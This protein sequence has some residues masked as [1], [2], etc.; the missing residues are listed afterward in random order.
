MTAG[1]FFLVALA[2][3]ELLSAVVHGSMQATIIVFA[4]GGFALGSVLEVARLRR[5]GRHD[6]ADSLLRWALGA[7][8]ILS[9]VVS[10][11]EQRREDAVERCAESP[12]E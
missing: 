11:G 4:V 10:S 12:S 1:V 9:V 2:I 3:G 6:I 5:L 8:V 7:A